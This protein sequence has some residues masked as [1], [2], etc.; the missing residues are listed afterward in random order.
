MAER[1]QPRRRYLVAVGT[2][3]ATGLAGCQER[4]GAPVFGSDDGSTETT[5]ASDDPAG[6]GAESIGNE[7][8]LVTKTRRSLTEQGYALTEQRTTTG[9]ISID[10][11]ERTRSSPVDERQLCVFDS[12]SKTEQVYVDG[13]TRYAQTTSEEE[14][15]SSTTERRESFDGNVDGTAIT[16]T[17]SFSLTKLG[18]VTVDR[19]EWIELV[20]DER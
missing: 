8:P 9:P 3:G 5:P 6:I 16:H 18:D 17:R 4:T 20:T 15:R 11:T 19:P 1:S 12:L 2:A 7:A 13:D 10:G 14:T